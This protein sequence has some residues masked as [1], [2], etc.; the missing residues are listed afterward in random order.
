MECVEFLLYNYW[1]LSWYKL[2]SG[3]T[4]HL[5]PWKE[6]K[7]RGLLIPNWRFKLVTNRNFYPFQ[8]TG[9]NFARVPTKS[10]NLFLARKNARILHYRILLIIRYLHFINRFCS[11]FTLQKRPKTV[12]FRLQKHSFY[13]LK[14]HLL[15]YKS[16]A[17]EC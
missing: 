1:V 14:H 7:E 12:F 10:F 9:C 3:Y 6:E 5:S 8:E 13:P 11:L 4:A 16:I 17:F 15:A 2:L